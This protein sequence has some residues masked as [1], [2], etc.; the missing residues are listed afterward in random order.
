MDPHVQARTGAVAAVAHESGLEVAA[1]Y[2]RRVGAGSE[3]EVASAA[4]TGWMADK[5][6]HAA[7]AA[8]AD[9]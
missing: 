8:V 7:A 3:A 1:V 2:I 5:C 9:S 4:R 6:M